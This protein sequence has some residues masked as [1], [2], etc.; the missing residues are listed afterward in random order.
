MPEIAPGWVR[1][2]PV[3]PI[4]SVKVKLFEQPLSRNV[5]V[6]LPTH[7]VSPSHEKLM[8]ADP[9][10]PLPDTEPETLARR[11]I[12]RALPDIVTPA[13]GAKASCALEPFQ[14]PVNVVEKLGKG[15]FEWWHEPS[16]QRDSPRSMK[17]A[18]VAVPETEP[19]RDRSSPVMT[20]VSIAPPWHPPSWK[21][22]T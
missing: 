10:G 21:S 12:T 2:S 3:K 7:G 17:L 19:L 14:V 18:N 1:F 9:A 8:F 22:A 13:G 4:R 6:P 16:G 15:P 5:A 20:I 11:L